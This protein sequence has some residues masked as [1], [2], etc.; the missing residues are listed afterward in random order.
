MISHLSH[1][2]LPTRDGPMHA[3]AEVLLHPRGHLPPARQCL[4][5][6]RQARAVA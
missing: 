5:R 1:H 3:A 2:H 4:D 6:T